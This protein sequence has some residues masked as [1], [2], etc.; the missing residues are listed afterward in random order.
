MLV[1]TPPVPT[2]LGLMQICGSFHG[3]HSALQ[4]YDITQCLWMAEPKIS[5]LKPT[6][7]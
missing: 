6:E 2:L 4:D 3:I 7:G 5:I 1:D